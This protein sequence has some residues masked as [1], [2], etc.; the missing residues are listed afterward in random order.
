MKIENYISAAER[1]KDTNKALLQGCQTLDDYVS[2]LLGALKG[3]LFMQRRT[4][5]NG[6]KTECDA[7]RQCEKDRIENTN[8]LD[9]IPIVSKKDGE[10]ND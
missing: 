2:E 10:N 8:L 5:K 7:P 3:E 6:S 1:I 9:C 4:R